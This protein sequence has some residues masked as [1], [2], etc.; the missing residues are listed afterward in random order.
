[1]AIL[2]A[3][4]FLNLPFH[5]V[6]PLKKE[7]KANICSPHTRTQEMLGFKMLIKCKP[8]VLPWAEALCLWSLSWNL[9]LDKETW[10][11]FSELGH[12]YLL[13]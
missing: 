5:M 12:L 7:E 8:S 10:S 13:L 2:V 6:H 4:L 11:L 1:M 9:T 3:K